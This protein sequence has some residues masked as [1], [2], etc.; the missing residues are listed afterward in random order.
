[1][2]TE[3]AD[4]EALAAVV[5]RTIRL[6]ATPIDFESLERSGVLK[7]E[8]AYYRLKKPGDLPEHA[9]KKVR[10]MIEDR[11]GVKLKFSKVTKAMEKLAAR[12]KI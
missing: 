6:M 12:L 5:A 11:H 7:K 4:D 2:N 10:T 3:N 9:W 8:G 1:M